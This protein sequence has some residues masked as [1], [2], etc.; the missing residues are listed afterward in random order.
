MD[1]NNHDT[2]ALR[3]VEALE[4]IGEREGVKEVLKDRKV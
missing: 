3:A 2:F 1:R 4:K